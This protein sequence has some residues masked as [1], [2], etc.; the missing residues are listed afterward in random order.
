MEERERII[1]EAQKLVVGEDGRHATIPEQLEAGF[2]LRRLDVD[3]N[4]EHCLKLRKFV[5]PK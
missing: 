3:P 1:K 5:G 2:P 4:T